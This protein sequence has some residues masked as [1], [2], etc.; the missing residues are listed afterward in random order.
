MVH[1][2]DII[3]LLVRYVVTYW[4]RCGGSYVDLKM[5][6]L[7]SGTPTAKDARGPAVGFNMTFGK[8]CF[9]SM[10]GFNMQYCKICTLL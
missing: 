1:W 4:W 7:S 2:L 6:F 10:A 9:W 5:W 3:G 8:P